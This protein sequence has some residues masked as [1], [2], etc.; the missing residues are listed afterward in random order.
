MI[1]TK[2]QNAAIAGVLRFFIFGCG[3]PE[4]FGKRAIAC[5]FLGGFHSTDISSACFQE[6]GTEPKGW[7]G[8]DACRRLNDTSLLPRPVLSSIRIFPFFSACGGGCVCT[9]WMRR[10]LAAGLLHGAV[11]SVRLPAGMQTLDGLR[12]GSDFFSGYPSLSRT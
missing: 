2:P 3:K 10:S 5:V 8:R 1:K 4:L 6:S 12:N 9:A 11:H 7:N